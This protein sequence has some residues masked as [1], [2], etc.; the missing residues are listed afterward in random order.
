MKPQFFDIEDL[1][2]EKS[3]FWANQ[4]RHYSDSICGNIY[5]VARGRK[6]R[7]CFDCILNVYYDAKFYYYGSR[8]DFN[9]RLAMSFRELLDKV[10]E[11]L[12]D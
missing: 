6:F 12:N 2:S 9:T 4:L 10:Y 7:V 3:C 11:L 5:F 1:K 8:K